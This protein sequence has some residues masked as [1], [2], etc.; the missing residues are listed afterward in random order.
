MTRNAHRTAR[1]ISAGSVALLVAMPVLASRADDQQ[2]QGWSAHHGIDSADLLRH[3]ETLPQGGMT[4]SDQP[5][6]APNDE[7][8]RTLR[9][10]F[11]E[12]P[13]ENAGHD[14][15]RLWGSDQMG[16]WTLVA[17]RQDQTSCIIASGIGYDAD[18]KA[19]IY[20]E[21]AGLTD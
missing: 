16:T 19:E 10:D 4:T 3:A 14:I 2:V 18:R 20:F 11:N 9:H 15:A 12:S 5:Y 8:D 13:V 1:L 6:C 7:I 21:T 17:E